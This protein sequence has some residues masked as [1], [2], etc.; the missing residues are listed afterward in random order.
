MSTKLNLFI[1][2]CTLAFFHGCSAYLR[3][4][5]GAGHRQ[6]QQQQKYGQCDIQRLTA[7]EPNRRI[8]AEAGVTEVWDQNTP[9]F[10]C[11]GVV[12]VRFVIQPGGLLLPF[13]SNAPSLTFVDQGKGVQGVVIPGCPATFQSEFQSE[14]ESSRSISDEHQKV[15]RIR[16]GDVIPSPA[17]VVQWTHNDGDTDLVGV[18]LFDAK[19]FHN[20][21]DENVRS[22]F[23][24]GQ[25]QSSS[26]H[27]E[28]PEGFIGG[29]ILSGF[30]K[31]I[32]QEVFR[33]ADQETISKIRSERDERGSIVQAKDLKLQIV[34]ESQQEEER[35]GRR[36]A[37]GV[38]ESI[39]NLKF[40]HNIADPYNT[41]FSY[42]RAGRISTLNSNILPILEIIRLSAER[43]VLYKN[44]I[45]GPKWN[46]NGHS[47]LYVR[48]GEGRV[49]VVGDGGEAV[50]DDV[51]KRGQ[52]L[53]VPQGF[54]VVVKAGGEG[55]EW[56]ELR[57]ND[58]VVSSPIAGRT[59]VLSSI[60]AEVLAKAYGISEGQAFKLKNARKEVGIFRPFESREE[61][62][63]ERYDVV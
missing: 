1:C 57:T 40:R 49:Q 21:L 23:L 6:Q 38:E 16:E 44:A 17:G 50:F 11:A 42:A 63:R 47:V 60:P 29:N 58:N 53:V 30:H 52:I 13:Y 26:K 3:H 61:T 46:V 33:G 19:S 48:D 56:V 34:G 54:A 35:V 10:R 14:S 2:L 27:Q 24:A 51:V 59:S 41:D 22:F 4:H 8:R 45:L 18:S 5:E 39:C 28:S 43:V 25:S 20:Q 37:N 15:F 32:L 9:G 7:S 12:A 31:E 36:G 55:L 62:E